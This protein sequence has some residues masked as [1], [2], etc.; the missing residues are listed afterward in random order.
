MTTSPL[1]NSCEKQ[2]TRYEKNLLLSPVKSPY[3]KN[4]S[5]YEKL[6]HKQV[7]RADVNK[8]LAYKKRQ[9]RQL[10]SVTEV[11]QYVQACNVAGSGNVQL[12]ISTLKL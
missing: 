3:R 8:L 5:P 12:Y 7:E 4:L 1:L 2:L 9:M 10:E 11:K 6:C